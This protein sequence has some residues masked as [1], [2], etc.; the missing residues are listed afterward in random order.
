[1][2]NL[3]KALLCLFYFKAVRSSEFLP[4]DLFEKFPI[5]NEV[6]NDLCVQQLNFFR[7][8]LD[9]RA[10][11][12]RRLRDSWGNFPSGVFSGNLYDFGN[13]DQCINFRHDSREVGEIVGQHCTLLI[14]H[15]RDDEELTAKFMP[16]SRIP[17]V[18]VGVGICVPAS[19]NPSQV[20]EIADDYLKALHNVTTSPSY[21]QR[22]FCSKAPPPLEF[23]GLQIC[24]M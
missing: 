23:N 7:E 6:S 9:Q 24:A 1:M 10:L 20:K 21:D 15:N 12:A 16:P 18:N 13:F 3:L 11:W 17:Q 19:C 22:T 5:K 4:S 14:P 8:N 2:K